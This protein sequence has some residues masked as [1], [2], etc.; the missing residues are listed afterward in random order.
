MGEDGSPPPAAHSLSQ[1]TK[2]LALC[3]EP[4]LP[5]EV[6][7]PDLCPLPRAAGRGTT[8]GGWFL[9]QSLPASKLILNGW[10]CSSFFSWGNCDPGRQPHSQL[11]GTRAKRHASLCPAQGSAPLSSTCLLVSLPNSLLACFHSFPQHRVSTVGWKYS[12]EQDGAYVVQFS[13]YSC[14]KCF[15]GDGRVLRAHK[16]DT[17]PLV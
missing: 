9:D 13:S 12:S 15:K 11:V 8:R 2:G 6:P 17:P 3:Q 14:T 7:R 16:W 1:E 4:S 5:A 10:S